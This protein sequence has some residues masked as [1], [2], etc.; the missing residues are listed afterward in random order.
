MS[1]V[2]FITHPNVKVDFNV[3]IPQWDLSEEGLKRLDELLKQ[4]WLKDIK[5]IFSSNEQKAKTAAL[6]IS[7]LLNFP[8]NYKEELGEMDRSSTGPLP[9][10]EFSKLVDEFFEKPNESIRGWEKATDTQN[11][12][13]KAIEEVLKEAPEGDIA[14]VAH[15]GVGALFLSHIK[16]I[17]ISRSEDQP[18][19]GYYFVFDRQS[20]ELLEEWKPID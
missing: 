12:I 10:E 7:E 3:P 6:K 17:S 8:V 11:R 20:Q 9:F 13:I 2:Y 14:I 19:Q 5:S 1:N 15:G 4:P 16:G 18:S